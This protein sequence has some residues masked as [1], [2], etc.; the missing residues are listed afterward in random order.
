MYMDSPLQ[1]L[2][3]TS[4]GEALTGLFMVEHKHGP[5]IEPT[6][7][8]DASVLPFPETKKQLQVYFAENMSERRERVNVSNLTCP[9]RRKGR[10]F[11]RK[12]G[13]N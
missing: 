5:E 13:K 10:I 12:C 2:L 8:E 6:W 11:K 9:L 1:P 7:V 4:N 3:L